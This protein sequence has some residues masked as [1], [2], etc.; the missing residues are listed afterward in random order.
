M[1][2]KFTAKF[3]KTYYGCIKRIGHTIGN[4][5][6]PVFKIKRPKTDPETAAQIAIFE[7]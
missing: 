7:V 1:K 4:K 6:Q 3:T 2:C 5:V